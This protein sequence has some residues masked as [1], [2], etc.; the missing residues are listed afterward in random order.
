MAR[1]RE[2]AL[3]HPAY[4]CTRHEALLALEGIR[5]SSITMQKILNHSGLGTLLERWLALEAKNADQAIA[6]SPEQAA[7]PEK[8][9]PCFRKR[10]VESSAHGE[11][12][13]ADTFFVGGLK[14][15]G[16]VYLHAV[17]DTFGRGLSGFS[18]VSGGLNITPPWP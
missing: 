4:G 1:I 16:K 8:L 10:H 3:L 17:V 6:I 13:S 5:V 18:C 15:A 7:F 12:L 9:N 14:G 11:M 2:L